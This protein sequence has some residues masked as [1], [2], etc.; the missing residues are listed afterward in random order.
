MKF[1]ILMTLL[2][3][4]TAHSYE[5]IETFS[6]YN[7]GLAHG[8]VENAE[9]RIQPLIN[10]LK[11]VNADV[12]CLNEIWRGKDR[13][14][15]IEN[16]KTTYPHAHYTKI[17][18][19]F[20]TKKPACKI[21]DLFGKGKFAS[22]VLKEC[23]GLED[24]E[25]TQ[26]LTRTCG[27]ALRA[28]QGDKRQCAQALMAQVGNSTVRSLLR[29]LTP[30][31]KAGL[32][33]Y[34]GGNGLL[35]LSKKPF[36]EKGL[37]DLTELSTLNRRGALKAKID[38]YQVYCAHL[39]ANLENTAPYTGPFE[40]WE[41]ENYAQVGK[42]L[43]DSKK[44]TEPV[45]MMGDFNCSPDLSGDGILPDFQSSCELFERHGFENFYYTQNPQC[46]FCDDNTIIAANP[47]ESG[48]KLIDHIFTR[49]TPQG[50]MERVFDDLKNID[51][52]DGRMKETHLSDHYGLL[53]RL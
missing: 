34:D 6:T 19:K 24:S 21:R 47:S 12:Y 52:G 49:S 36:Q 37:V 38:G 44:I 3:A 33:A 7:V 46:T 22:C 10:E 30:F 8:F 31:R 43:E 1:M 16:L 14:Q 28:L 51:L 17:T 11:A 20:S 25:F 2:L 40:N 41:Q 4:S 35:M 18:Q 53:L 13:D 5:E 27:P 23:R 42:L 26:C 48:K 39:S 32:F 9:E 50:F 15:F 29:V 45:V